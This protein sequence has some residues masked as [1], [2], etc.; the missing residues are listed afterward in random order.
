M[1]GRNGPIHCTKVLRQ[2][3]YEVTGLPKFTAYVFRVIA[4]N[5]K[6]AS[7]PAYT[8]ARTLEDCEL[9]CFVVFVFVRYGRNRTIH[10][11]ASIQAYCD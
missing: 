6:G 9:C 11:L 2:R 3:D 4:M 1:R 10:D 5:S 7:P 8:Q